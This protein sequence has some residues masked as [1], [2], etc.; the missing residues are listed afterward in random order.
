MLLIW[1][2][3]REDRQPFLTQYSVVALNPQSYH[4]C[5]WRNSDG[6]KR[7]THILYYELPRAGSVP[8]Y[9]LNAS[10]AKQERLSTL[11]RQAVFQ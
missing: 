6:K 11:T 4:T 5:I 7:P 1:L 9:D 8:G 3:A 2:N 10:P